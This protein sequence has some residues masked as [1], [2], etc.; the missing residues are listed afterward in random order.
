MEIDPGGYDWLK[1]RPHGMGRG[2]ANGGS[3]EE[4]LPSFPAWVLQTA[5][6]CSSQL[7]PHTSYRSPDS[8]GSPIVTIALCSWCNPTTAILNKNPKDAPD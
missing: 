6:Q 8:H 3:I 2:A 4:F 5:L 1:A 7:R